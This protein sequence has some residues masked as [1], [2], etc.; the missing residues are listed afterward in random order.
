V[1]DLQGKLY[2]MAFNSDQLKELVPKVMRLADLFA[3]PMVMTEQ[4][5]KGLGHTAPSIRALYDEISTEKHLLEK[6][7][8]GCC[9]EPGFNE[10]IRT[11]TSSVQDARTEWSDPDRPLEILVLGIETHVCVQQTVLELL[12]RGYRVVVLEDCTGCRSEASHRI[13]IER[14]RQCGA[15]IS[16]YESVAFEWA[17]T[18]DDERFKQMSAIIKG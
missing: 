3:V 7:F 8:F 12:K 15:I 4:Y 14:F 2:E 18:K 11:L 9:G 5:P 6:S 1:I 17:R 16:S 10:L 13:A